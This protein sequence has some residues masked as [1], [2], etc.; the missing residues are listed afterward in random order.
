MMKNKMMMIIII[1][2]LYSNKGKCPMNL[3]KN[4]PEILQTNNLTLPIVKSFSSD[5]GS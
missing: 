2:A 3:N 4:T 1:I 5:G